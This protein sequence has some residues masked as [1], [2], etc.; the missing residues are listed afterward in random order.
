ME[1]LEETHQSVTG[2]KQKECSVWPPTLRGWRGV[3]MDSFQQMDQ[4]LQIGP[5]N[6]RIIN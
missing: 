2:A 4:R 3:H 6:K 1:L 5:S